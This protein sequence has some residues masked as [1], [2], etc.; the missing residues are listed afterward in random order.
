METTSTQIQE[1]N[2][3]SLPVSNLQ[4]SNNKKVDNSLTM[5]TC[6]KVVD[7]QQNHRDRIRCSELLVV[8]QPKH[9]CHLCK[10]REDLLLQR[11]RQIRALAS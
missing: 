11:C 7:Q 9:Q 2:Q 10:Y 4:G 5:Q 3:A 8:T 1:F 6:M